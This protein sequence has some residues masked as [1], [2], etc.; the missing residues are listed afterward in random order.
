VIDA[1]VADKFSEYDA[2]FLLPEADHLVAVIEPGDRAV[3]NLKRWLDAICDPPGRA[4]GDGYNPERVSVIVNRYK[5]GVGLHYDRIRHDL[6]PFKVV[7]V[8]P[9]S[10]D[11]TRAVYDANLF[12]LPQK[13]FNKIAELT[14]LVTHDPSLR[15]IAPP[16]GPDKPE[17][18]KKNAKQRQPADTSRNASGFR[19]ALGFLL[20]SNQN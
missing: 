18:G 19:K 12:S 7:G 11:W 13:M 1:P 17:R 14:H 3:K 10:E 5:E 16:A 8:L 6:Q 9:L 15:D 20:G 2:R 4:G